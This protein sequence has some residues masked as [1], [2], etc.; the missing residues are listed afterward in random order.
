MCL[1][2]MWP[3]ESLFKKRNTNRYNQ[4]QR[5]IQVVVAQKNHAWTWQYYIINKWMKDDFDIMIETIANNKR[6][7]SQVNQ[8]SG[9]REREKRGHKIEKEKWERK[10]ERERERGIKI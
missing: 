8:V 9:R 4:S 1:L 6:D 3:N 7:K 5:T 2:K 10:K